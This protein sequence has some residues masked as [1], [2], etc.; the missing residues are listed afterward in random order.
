MARIPDRISIDRA[1]RDLYDHS[2][3]KSE[4]FSNRTRKEEFLFAM[5]VGFNRRI[6]RPLQTREG[7]FLSKDMTPHDEALID[8]VAIAETS[9]AEILSD[10]EMVFRIAEEYAHAG[11]RLIHDQITSGQPGS[12]SKKLEV[13][14]SA[15]LESRS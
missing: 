5:A 6:R 15:L 10:K 4:V 11:I 3:V 8:V 9:S 7:F 1:D 12:F 13:E 2:M 14:L